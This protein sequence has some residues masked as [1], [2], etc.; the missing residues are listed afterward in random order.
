MRNKIR[1]AIGIVVL[2]AAA[3]AMAE[4][5]FRLWGPP[6]RTRF[7][8]DSQTKKIYFD[9]NEPF[10]RTEKK[11]GEWFLIQNPRL[12]AFMPPQTFPLAKAPGTKRILV[13]GESSSVVLARAIKLLVAQIGQS[14]KIEVWACGVP[15]GSLEQAERRFADVSRY[16]PDLI[17][18]LFGHNLGYPSNPSALP[19]W[20]VRIAILARKSH[21]IA[22]ASDWMP[23]SAPAE[24]PL[25]KRW[26]ALSRFLRSLSR[27]AHRRH[28]PLVLCTVPGNL[29]FP[30]TDPGRTGQGLWE[31]NFLFWA[32]CRRKA[33][34]HLKTWLA[35]HLSAQG[36][37][38][39][40]DWLYQTGR[41]K[42]AYQC[43]ARERDMDDQPTRASSKVNAIIRQAAFKNKDWLLDLDRDVS[44]LAAAGVP[45]WTLFEDWQHVTG[46]VAFLEAAK[47]W[48]LLGNK[49]WRP[50]NARS[51][52]V[53]FANPPPLHGD[54]LAHLLNEFLSGGIDRRFAP[55]LASKMADDLGSEN[56]NGVEIIRQ[57]KE[58]KAPDAVK[59]SLF[60]SIGEGYWRAKRF[61]EAYQF[62][63]LARALVPG[64]S[65]PWIQM[66]FYRLSVQDRQDAE[67]SF[68]K[69]V[70]LEP[71]NEEA[72]FYL[73]ESEGSLGR[74]CR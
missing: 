7:F 70:N 32:G 10:F 23:R 26:E 6:V 43:L 8:P 38:D 16:S 63:R 35:G 30:P 25:S 20:A 15:G 21:L 40:G 73:R 29:M 67:N 57:I 13:I 14:G 24:A 66:G 52:A 34:A 11:N 5:V 18:W 45:E 9:I 56:L 31:A 22:A 60:L 19:P 47:L 3:F 59:A 4:W 69:A 41:R 62:N 74:I 68:K 1:I 28:V 39:L 55:A 12:A 65:Q 27:F 42:L 71:A 50:P 2:V 37:F 44:G 51:P 54:P 49:G 53:F 61:K 33:I 48:R 58:A 36:W 64:S 46:E 17:V 72:R